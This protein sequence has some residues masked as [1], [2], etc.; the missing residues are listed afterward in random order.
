[1]QVLTR[2]INDHLASEFQASHAYLAMSI[3]LRENDLAGFAGYMLEKSNEERG[4]A[5]RMIAYLVDCD[6]EVELPTIQAPRREWESLQQLFDQ[7]FDMEKEVTASINRLY[8]MADASGE[9][10]A[11]SMLDWFVQEQIQEEAEA[12][13]VRRRL[14]LAG[15]NSAALLLL[16]QQFLEGTALAHVKGQAGGKGSP[17]QP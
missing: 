1:M 17:G 9:R 15:D 11:S 8:A 13:F 3:W 5:A 7:V 14:R 4:H 10:S 2:A 12:R 6:A 16:D